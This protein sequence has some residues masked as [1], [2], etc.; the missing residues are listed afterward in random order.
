VN[1]LP[2]N[3]HSRLNGVPRFIYCSRCEKNFYILYLHIKYLKP[4]GILLGLVR[5]GI[6]GDRSSGGLL[7]ASCNLQLSYAEGPIAAINTLL[8]RRIAYESSTTSTRSAPTSLRSTRVLTY[9][10]FEISNLHYLPP[11]PNLR[12]KRLIYVNSQNLR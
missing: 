8:Y 12:Q 2:F 4:A 3:L 5:A 10:L 7:S 1:D 6:A 11:K 9:I